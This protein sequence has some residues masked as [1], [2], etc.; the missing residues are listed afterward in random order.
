MDNIKVV[1]ILK[2]SRERDKKRKRLL[3]VLGKSI[4]RLTRKE[5]IDLLLALQQS[6]VRL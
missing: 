5:A 3:I 4:L 2:E 6:L 1:P